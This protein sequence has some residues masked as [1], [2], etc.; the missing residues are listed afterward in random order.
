MVKNICYVNIDHIESEN[1][2]WK[3]IFYVQYFAILLYRV[4]KFAAK[5]IKNTL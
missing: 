4:I 5:F 1:G 2:F 3:F